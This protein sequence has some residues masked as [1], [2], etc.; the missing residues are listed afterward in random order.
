LI[1]LLQELI[2]N[3]TT[4]Q[5]TNTHGPTVAWPLQLGERLTRSGVLT[6]QTEGLLFRPESQYVPQ[7]SVDCHFLSKNKRE[8][9][10]STSL[11]CS[12][13]TTRNEC[14]QQ[15]DALFL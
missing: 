9:V 6:A 1:V 5:P 8:H 15:S 12:Q 10:F 14:E 3:P 4:S 13:L 11:A 7:R 2:L